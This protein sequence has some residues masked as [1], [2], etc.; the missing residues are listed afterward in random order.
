[1]MLVILEEIANYLQIDDE[2][3]LRKHHAEYHYVDF[4]RL[5]TAAQREHPYKEDLQKPS[6]ID[7]HLHC[8]IVDNQAYSAVTDSHMFADR[9]M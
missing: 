8:K 7:L 4:H 3:D 6:C 9:Q 2:A 1:M 5:I